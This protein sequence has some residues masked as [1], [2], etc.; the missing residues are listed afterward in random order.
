MSKIPQ[1]IITMWFEIR[2]PLIRLSHFFSSSVCASSVSMVFRGLGQLIRLRVKN[3][4]MQ[5]P[6]H[7]EGLTKFHFRRCCSGCPAIFSST[8]VPCYITL[9]LDAWRVYTPRV[10]HAIMYSSL[11]LAS[12]AFWQKQSP[13]GPQTNLFCFIL[14]NGQVPLYQNYSR[15]YRHNSGCLYLDIH[16]SSI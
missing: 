3:I 15:A 11:P 2:S 14:K 6:K 10:E 4:L 9:G 8:Q 12:Q 7:K 16:K 1:L 5:S 13:R